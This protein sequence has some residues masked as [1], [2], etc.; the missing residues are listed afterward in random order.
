MSGIIEVLSGNGHDEVKLGDNGAENKKK[1]DELLGKKYTV[2]VKVGEGDAA[3]EK[4][5]TSFD[6]DKNEYVVK[7]KVGDAE[8]ETRV[9]A[10]VVATAI[11]PLAGG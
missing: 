4:K 9:A 7:E 10:S 8:T 1:V 11:A 5:V 2:M 6:A 3:K